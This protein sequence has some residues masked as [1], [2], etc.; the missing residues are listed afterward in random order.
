MADNVKFVFHL[1]A[2]PQGLVN[3]HL[4][5]HRIQFGCRSS[6]S[7]ASTAHQCHTYTRHIKEVLHS[8]SSNDAMK[9]GRQKFA[10]KIYR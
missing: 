2:S 3:A 6:K 7:V 4:N 1:V 8:V 5:V 10:T 9:V